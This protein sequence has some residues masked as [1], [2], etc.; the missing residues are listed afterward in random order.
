MMNERDILADL[1][2]WRDEFARS[3]GYDLAAMA[4]SLRASD[5][6]SGIQVVRGEPRRPEIVLPP[7]L[8]RLDVAHPAI[9][10]M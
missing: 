7:E 4:A 5:R 2:A 6:A 3:H 9:G 1:Q 10:T 8:P